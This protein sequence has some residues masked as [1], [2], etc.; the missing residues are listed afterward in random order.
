MKTQNTRKKMR[1]K[2]YLSN[3]D[4][5]L[6]DFSQLIDRTPEYMSRV[7]N[8]HAKIGKRLAEYIEELTKGKVKLRSEKSEKSIKM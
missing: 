6:K 4:M 2:D 7:I 8:G 1:L 3:I 5:T